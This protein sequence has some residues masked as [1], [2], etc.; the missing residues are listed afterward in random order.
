MTGS[1]VPTTDTLRSA[2]ADG[3]SEKVAV[4]LREVPA[5]AP[6]AQ[7]IAFTLVV[8]VITYLSLVI[9]ELV[10]K[11]IGL[12]APERISGILAGP[13]GGMRILTS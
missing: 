3:M 5:I 4:Y 11:R 7:P 1:G 8:L 2:V 9:G 13:M 12:S 6:Y 10:P